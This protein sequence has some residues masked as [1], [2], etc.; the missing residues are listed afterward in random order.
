MSGRSIFENPPRYHAGSFEEELAEVARKS[1][2][3]LCAVTDCWVPGLGW[4]QTQTARVPVSLAALAV[5]PAD[6]LHQ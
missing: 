4:A 5:R 3:Q 2:G 1:K 6:E